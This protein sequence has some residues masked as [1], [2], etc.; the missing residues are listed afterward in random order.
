M[1]WVDMD[2]VLADFDE[3][4]RQR[5]GREADGTEPD[6]IFWGRVRQEPDFFRNLPQMPGARRLWELCA[7]FNGHVLTALAKSI[8][9]CLPQKLAWL[10]EFGVSRD[11]VVAVLGRGN[12][13]LYCQPGDLLIDN[14]AENVENWRQA[15]GAAI[16]YTR[17]G[18]LSA[19]EEHIRNNGRSHGR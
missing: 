7:P 13:V 8:P 1:I 11:R 19:V 15:G 18:G 3:G 12:K 14:S 6:D 4:Y 2:G 17:E 16:L 10:R 9:A 5:F